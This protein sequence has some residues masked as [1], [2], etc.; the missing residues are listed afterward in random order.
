MSEDKSKSTQHRLQA[1]WEA[2]E[3]DCKEKNHDIS[4]CSIN[5]N[6]FS[7]SVHRAASSLPGHDEYGTL[8][9]SNDCSSDMQPTDSLAFED[10]FLLNFSNETSPTSQTTSSSSALPST[11]QRQ[12]SQQL[13][14][15]M[16]SSSSPSSSPS[17]LQRYRTFLQKHE[18]LLSL[19]EMIMER[20]VF[21]GH[22]FKVQHHENDDGEEGMIRTEMYY[23]TWN[24]IRWVNDVILVGVGDG[25]GFTVGT[26]EEW[27]SSSSEESTVNN[28]DYS[29]LL[30]LQAW[31]SSRMYRLVPIIRATLTATTCIY[32]AIESYS[33]K[34]ILRQWSGG[35]AISNSVLT[36]NRNNDWEVRRYRA[37]L[38]SYRLERLRFM[39]R[40]CLLVISWWGKLNLQKR[41]QQQEKHEQLFIP[42]LLQR[43]GE[44]DPYEDL[45]SLKDAQ[46]EA[47][48]VQYVGRR[49]GRRSI[50]TTDGSTSLQQR[51]D[52]QQR[53]ISAASQHLSF[54]TKS[55]NLIEWLSKVLTS[56][57]NKLV[58]V[59]AV[60][61]ILHILRPLYWSNAECGEW[62]RRR[63][64][65]Q[66]QKQKRGGLGSFNS[67]SIWKAWWV[68]LL[69]DVISDKLL[70]LSINSDGGG[71]DSLNNNIQGLR[72]GSAFMG[73]R[74]G[75]RQSLT[76][77][78]HSSFTSSAEEAKLNELERRRSRHGLYL[79]R[80]PMYDVVSRPIASFI[81]RVVSMIPSMGLGQWA[82]E[83]V[84]DMM[85]YWQSNHFMLES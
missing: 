27:L 67:W 61:E 36:N 74:G 79:L 43:G 80:S 6:G 16:M 24:V 59:Y 1:A 51:Q 55:T 52:L 38:T 64:Q 12:Q 56:S 13:P 54:L 69:M 26:R 29:S 3:E 46:D 5:E 20:F 58:Y 21:Y 15:A 49:T 85:T 39:M 25:M 63:M 75:K 17:V 57:G 41:Q 81:A 70:R 19:F 66:Q 62:H 47:R 84:L 32:P 82:A 78:H 4:I 83:Y 2:A 77:Y 9:L 34:S 18:P 68:S 42:S 8:T 11:K 40:M 30:S 73:R 65:Q 28:D 22:L 76:H 72:R 50:S 48:V 35:T 33:R 14:T 7:A 44:L 53:T 10:P 37:A 23:A 31:I 45:V 71:E 60:G